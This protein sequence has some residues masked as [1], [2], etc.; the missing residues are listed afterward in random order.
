MIESEWSRM[1]HEASKEREFSDSQIFATG[2]DR[3]SD[4]HWIRFLDGRVVEVDSTTN[5]AA[6]GG[7]RE[8]LRRKLLELADCE[9]D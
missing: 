3:E 2:I 8:T 5:V 6:P 7:M 9:P 4:R 1:A